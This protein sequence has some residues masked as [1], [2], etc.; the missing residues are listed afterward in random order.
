M[1]IPIGHDQNEV[2]RFPL[3]TFCLISLCLIVHLD[4]APKRAGYDQQLE[5][6]AYRIFGLYQSCPSIDSEGEVIGRLVIA[7]R[8]EPAV[9]YARA[10]GE[11]SHCRSRERAEAELADLVA[12]FNEHFL[13]GPLDQ[14]TFIP[15]AGEGASDM[16]WSGF[17]HANWWHLGFNMLFLV[18]F[19]VPLENRWGRLPFLFFYLIALVAAG[20]VTAAFTFGPRS[21]IPSLGASGAIAATMGAFL[22]LFGR[23]RLA[24]LFWQW[25]FTGFVFWLPA[26]I[27]IVLWMSRDLFGVYSVH[28]LGRDSGIGHWAHLGGMGFRLLV[29]IALVRTGLDTK[30]RQAYGDD[31]DAPEYNVIEKARR[32]EEIGQRQVAWELLTEALRRWPTNFDLAHAL[33]RLERGRTRAQEISELVLPALERELHEGDVY[34]AIELLEDLRASLPDGLRLSPDRLVR[35]AVAIASA[36]VWGT[37]DMLAREM[38]ERAAELEPADLLRMARLTATFDRELAGHLARAA[39]ANDR[40]IAPYLRS[41]LQALD[42]PPDTRAATG[43]EPLPVSHFPSPFEAATS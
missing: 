16:V 32:H 2:R 37:V 36:R 31:I 35:F 14:F 23:S 39:L 22:V 24:L 30:L 10:L 5:T 12:R 15:G 28:V 1:F 13:D 18:L 7:E 3:A 38:V 21:F 9:A 19:G 11:G 43:S 42:S 25:P 8:F 34:S 27:P 4:S 6:M 20:S 17:A 26:W 41:R 29:A 33:W 40:V